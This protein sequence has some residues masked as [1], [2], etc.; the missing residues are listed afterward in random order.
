MSK[1]EMIVLDAD[2]DDDKEEAPFLRLL[3]VLVLSDISGVGSKEHL[4]VMDSSEGLS[5]RR[6]SSRY[7]TLEL[8]TFSLGLPTQHQQ[9]SLPMT[10]AQRFPQT[11]RH[12]CTMI[13]ILL[14]LT[15]NLTP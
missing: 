9:K 3:L 5:P 12:S 13:S 8:N 6:G 11:Q 1:S 4:L 14:S 7:C 15:Y 10:A 2:D